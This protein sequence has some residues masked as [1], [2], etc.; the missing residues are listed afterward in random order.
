MLGGLWARRSRLFL[1]LLN[2]KLKSGFVSRLT[3]SAS[4]LS[5]HA[6]LHLLLASVGVGALGC[7]VGTLSC[8]IAGDLVEH[9]VYQLDDGVGRL[10]VR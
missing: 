8:C 10:R 4:Y 5:T 9:F 7:G 6:G 2:T 1:E 3:L